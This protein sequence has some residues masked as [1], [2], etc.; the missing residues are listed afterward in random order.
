MRNLPKDWREFAESLNAREVRYVI[1]GALAVAYH[2]WPRMTGDIDVLV[3]PTEANA[4]RLEAALRDFGFGSLGLTASDFLVP[5]RVVRLGH[6]PN[7]I[8]ILTSLTGVT[9]AEAWA[10]KCDATLDGVP[11]HFL[12][13]TELERNK[14]ACGRPTDLADLDS[15]RGPR[16]DRSGGAA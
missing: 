11:V 9:F 14:K 6:Q 15:L 3:E 8:D 13:R 7:R 5:N 2:G 12:G 1:V 4:R 10:G 16:P